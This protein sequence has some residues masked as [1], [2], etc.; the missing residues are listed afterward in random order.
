MILSKTLRREGEVCIAS[1]K[2]A[3]IFHELMHGMHGQ[4]EVIS[5]RPSSMGNKVNYQSFP[6]PMEAWN[7]QTALKTSHYQ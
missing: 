3:Y 1:L 4:N 5:P 7:P 6:E 2:L